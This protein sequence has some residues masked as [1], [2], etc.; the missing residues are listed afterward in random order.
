M[1][2]IETNTPN[3]S[4]SFSKMASDVDRNKDTLFGGAAVLVPPGDDEPISLLV[5][6]QANP[7]IFWASMKTLVEQKLVQLDAA[8]RQ[9]L[10]GFGRR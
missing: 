1:S 9:G 5:L 8:E 6:N 10:G 3:H 2:L 7:V 4:Q